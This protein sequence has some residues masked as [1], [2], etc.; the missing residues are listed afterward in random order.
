CLAV[1]ERSH[2]LLFSAC[3]IDHH[4]P[5][6]GYRLFDYYP[7]RKTF[8]LNAFYYALFHLIVFLVELTQIKS[9]YEE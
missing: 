6:F 7:L 3:L 1:M 4:P 2:R 9:N 5:P 8:G